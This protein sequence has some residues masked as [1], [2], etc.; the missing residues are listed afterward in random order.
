MS[1][2]KSTSGS[3]L[4]VSGTRK[5]RGSG[6]FNFSASSGPA[7]QDYTYRQNAD[8][9]SQGIM[10]Y[11]DYIA[12]LQ[13]KLDGLSEG[14]SDYLSIEKRIR[15]VSEAYDKNIATVAKQQSDLEQ[16]Q[17]TADYQ[18]G[19]VG[20]A[21]YSKFLSDKM[22]TLDPE[23][24]EYFSV[25]KTLDNITEQ[26]TDKQMD[27]GF[28][29]AKTIEPDDYIKWKQ[30]LLAKTDPSTPAYMQLET[31]IKSAQ[32]EGVNRLEDSAKYDIMTGVANKQDL[33]K[34]YYGVANATDDPQ[35]QMEYM[36]KYSNT[37]DSINSEALAEYNQ[38]V[39]L[40]DRDMALKYR[41][42]DLGGTLQENA[43]AMYDYLNDR[44]SKEADPNKQM[45]LIS[46]MDGIVK[47]V[48]DEQDQ[49]GAKA[50]A[51][52]ARST[53]ASAKAATQTYNAIKDDY[54]SKKDMLEK[55]LNNG[56][57]STDQYAMEM[58]NLT[59]DYIKEVSTAG[60]NPNLSD[61]TFDSINGEIEKI[62]KSFDTDSFWKSN[63]A[64]VGE[65][66]QPT[67]KIWHNPDY[68]PVQGI[69][70]QGNMKTTW[71]LDPTQNYKLKDHIW[72]AA[73][74]VWRKVEQ[75]DVLD[76]NGNVK[77]DAN[78][79]NVTRGEIY[80]TDADGNV[81]VE[82][83]NSD[84]GEYGTMGDD[85]TF[86][87][88]SQKY[89][90]A[91]LHA[92]AYGDN[93]QKYNAE[94]SGKIWDSYSQDMKKSNPLVGGIL[95]GAGKSMV[96]NPGSWLNNLADGSKTMEN[97]GGAAYNSVENFGKG[98]ADAADKYVYNPIGGAIKG[99]INL[100][101]NISSAANW[102]IGKTGDEVS[103]LQK[104]LGLTISGYFGPNTQKA[105]NNA[106]AQ[107]KTTLADPAMATGNYMLKNQSTPVGSVLNKLADGGQAIENGV[108]ATESFFN[109]IS[110]AAKNWV[111]PTSS[112]GGALG[113]VY[114]K[115]TDLQQNF[116][117]SG[118]GTS[119]AWA[120]KTINDWANTW[121]Y[122]EEAS[123]ASYTPKAPVIKIP[124]ANDVKKTVSAV[125]KYNPVVAP[126]VNAA[127][128]VVAPVVST[129][130]AVW[131][132]NPTVN[133]VKK[134]AGN[135]SNSISST[136]NKAASAAS[137]AWNKLKW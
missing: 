76:E 126:I 16:S 60:A 78:G 130:S 54:Y 135:V 117:A 91:N 15:S 70:D 94:Q 14:T 9:Y 59:N 36:T 53:A 30:D 106:V 1:L 27:Y 100:P 26:Q 128:K 50:T 92:L 48:Q 72:D 33:A 63:I 105:V 12:Y 51:A 8:D 102:A 38:Q 81:I 90:E 29:T 11:E 22:E 120:G 95:A 67:G 69:D 6:S 136:L 119:A 123:L 93:M 118:K 56:S 49:Q 96:D 115:R 19:L 129:A 88:S 41:R 82:Y 17:I 73:A 85:G 103:Q 46:Q 114:S 77:K 109:N 110:T 101:E 40:Q 66:G 131:N 44:L 107:I 32:W 20:Y 121:G 55:G 24:L 3:L 74:G 57:I 7:L 31:D 116:D 83:Q 75:V 134:V 84:T 47:A 97:I 68:K 125:I 25:Q 39:G 10:S 86:K 65:N 13:S 35:K 58:M 52:G 111:M 45:S 79:K 99:A 137:A 132:Y 112:I 42:G 104:D 89:N 4:K 2:R 23:S 64:M 34:F 113:D 61:S 108:K 62:Q 37:V 98:F 133:A 71:K 87:A 43:Q 80:R 127:K 18:N 21:T 124:T 122:K 5:K 28:K